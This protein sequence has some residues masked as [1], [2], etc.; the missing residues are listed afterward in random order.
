MS[1]TSAFAGADLSLDDQVPEVA[2]DNAI[3]DRV[4][5][6]RRLKPKFR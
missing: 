5:R 3:V 2:R 1:G 6:G 4:F